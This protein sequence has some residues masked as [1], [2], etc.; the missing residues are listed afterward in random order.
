VAAEPQLLLGEERTAAA[1][2]TPEEVAAAELERERFVLRRA[3]RSSL[4]LLVIGVG[5]GWL[6]WHT[7]TSENK[8]HPKAVILAV[9]GLMLGPVG[10]IWPRMMMAVGRDRVRVPLVYKIVG[11][12]WTV[13]AVAVGIG[14]TIWLER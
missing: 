2:P 4:L 1:A 11:I 9:V 6:E 5:L 13:L 12:A 7:L 8:F 14:L 10:L 3:R